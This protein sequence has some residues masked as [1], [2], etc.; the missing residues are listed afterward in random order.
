MLPDF[1]LSFMFNPIRSGLFQTAND[2]LPPTISKTNVN[3]YHII[4]VNFTRFSGMFQIEF[5]EN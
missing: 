2:P 5:L 4:H 1:A 3:L